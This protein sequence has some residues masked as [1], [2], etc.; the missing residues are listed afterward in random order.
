MRDLPDETRGLPDEIDLG[1]VFG[2]IE[3]EGGNG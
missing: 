1:F 2:S 3:K